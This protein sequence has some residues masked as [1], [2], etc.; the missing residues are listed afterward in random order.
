MTRS[1]TP[2][3]DVATSSA[4]IRGIFFAEFGF[5]SG[6][7]RLTSCG[8][9]VNWNG[10][11]WQGGARISMDEVRESASLEA[12]GLV[13]EL[14]GILPSAIAL[15]LGEFVKGRPVTL[16]F[17]P[18]DANFQVIAD[19]SIEFLGTID[20][21][22]ITDGTQTTAVRVQCESRMIEWARATKLLYT[23]EQQQAMFPGDRFFEFVPELVEK[24]IV[25]PAKAFFAR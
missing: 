10:Y 14:P 22:S 20:R 21:M 8:T 1:T 2:A 11:T 12:I 18:L 13:F 4:A 23:N 16:W 7:L 15:A 24:Q 5:S 19:P 6:T 25:W 3:F 9:D 17:A